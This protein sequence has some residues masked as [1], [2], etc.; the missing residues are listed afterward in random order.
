M[1]Q[2]AITQP[3][4]MTLGD[5]IRVLWRHRWLVLS[6][7]VV[8]A[9]L[10]AALA[11]FSEPRYRAEVVVASAGAAPQSQIASLVGRLGGLGGLADTLGGSA[12]SAAENLALLQSEEF[13]SAFIAERDLL[14]KLF[15]KQWDEAK[16]QWRLEPGDAPPSLQ[17]G[18]RRFTAAI[19]RV[20]VDKDDALIHLT[21]EWKDPRV[22]AEWANEL[23]AR[24]NRVIAQRA[25]LDA[26][27]SIDYL[28]EELA[29]TSQ[30][31]LQ[32]SIYRLVETQMNSA[33]LASVR[34]DFA[35]RVVSPAIAS[36][37]HRKVS[38]K[39]ARMIVLGALAGLI[40]ASVIALTAR[41]MRA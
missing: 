5:T 21:I 14:P 19:M 18:H 16:R 3:S 13:L 33:M 32:Q 31:E 10:A 17:D 1:D 9:L 24:A 27:R 7:I 8:C 41:G 37:L 15:P 34:K 11:Y 28:R 20:K 2:L 25:L 35:F 26:T 36:D 40:L 38:P 30:L 29:R 12:P 23:I 4:V 39:P 6:A 22:A